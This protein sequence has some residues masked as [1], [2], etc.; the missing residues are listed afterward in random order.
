MPKTS[1]SIQQ[2]LPVIGDLVPLPPTDD[3]E[4]L[5]Y[6]MLI[7]DDKIKIGH[8]NVEQRRRV[9]QTTA[10]SPI[11][12]LATE[13]GGAAVERERHTTF[14]CFHIPNA[15]KE[16]FRPDAA[17]LFAIERINETQRAH[18]TVDET[19]TTVERLIDAFDQEQESRRRWEEHARRAHAALEGS[20][21]IVDRLVKLYE[22]E[23]SACAHLAYRLCSVVGLV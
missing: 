3:E 12:V 22:R 21:A 17:L 20:M 7:D 9:Y 11:L 23:K 6:Y 5:V 13:P 2:R 16:L 1:L 19:F 4:D 8:G 14:E 18:Q 10:R 15:P